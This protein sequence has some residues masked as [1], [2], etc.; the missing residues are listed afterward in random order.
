MYVD[1]LPYCKPTPCKLTSKF[2]TYM[3]NRQQDITSKGVEPD[4]SDI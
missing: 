2:D 3:K 4:A 1:S